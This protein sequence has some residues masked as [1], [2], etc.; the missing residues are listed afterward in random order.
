VALHQMCLPSP[1]RIHP[2]SSYH[3]VVEAQNVF[4]II[5]ICS[6]NIIIDNTMPKF[7]FSFFLLLEESVLYRTYSY[8][9]FQ[10]SQDSTDF[11]AQN[12]TVL[13]S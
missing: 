5:I 2:I 10:L 8:V 9:S 11:V 4:A 1:P 7:D 13:H 6:H 3:K 12:V